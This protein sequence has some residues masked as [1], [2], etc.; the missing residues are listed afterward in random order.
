MY[1]MLKVLERCTG[2]LLCGRQLCFHWA[3]FPAPAC[4]SVCLCCLL[5]LDML[6]IQMQI[7][8]V[9]QSLCFF[10]C[11]LPPADS[12]Y[13]YL[14]FQA[15]QTSPWY[16]PPSPPSFPPSPSLPP[17]LSLSLS[18]SLSLSLSLSLWCVYV[19]Y[20]VHVCVCM[21]VWRAACTC[22]CMYVEVDMGFCTLHLT[23]SLRQGFSREE[24]PDLVSLDSQLTPEIT[25]PPSEC[26]GCHAWPACN[27]CLTRWAISPALYFS[28]SIIALCYQQP[29]VRH[30]WGLKNGSEAWQDG[31]VGKG[32]CH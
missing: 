4:E 31:L 7:W 29:T 6:E 22:M 21:H 8:A 10:F 26:W 18:Q 5:K 16:L 9:S 13:M 12:D 27:K 15:L 1:L 11:L 28:V 23:Y 2:C 32:A 25:P 14:V 3:A 30:E 20:A 19:W 24:L 17:P